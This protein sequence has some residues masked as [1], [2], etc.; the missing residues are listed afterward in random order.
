[1]NRRSLLTS[2]GG[3]GAGGLAV[4]GVI[5]WRR[6]SSD[7]TVSSGDDDTTVRP[8]DGEGPDDEKSAIYLDV[9]KGGYGRHNSNSVT[10]THDAF[11]V[12][13]RGKTSA[14]IWIDAD[15][16]ENDRGE[17]TVQFYRGRSLDERVDAPHVAVTID[18]DECLGVGLLTRTFGIAAETPLVDEVVV[19]TDRKA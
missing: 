17:P 16:I 5:Y 6:D 15:P 8:P 18:P 7:T 2:L 4:G 11:Y 10:F 19:R 3:V 1:M 14:S 9:P 12:C 13:N